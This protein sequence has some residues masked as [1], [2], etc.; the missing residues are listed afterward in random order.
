M[1]TSP[2]HLRMQTDITRENLSRDVDALADKVSPSA[3]VGRRKASMQNRLTRMRTAVMGSAEQ[4]TST[5][6]DASRSAMEGVAEAGGAVTA[7]VQEAP[8]QIKRTTQGSPIAA[9]LVAFG[10]G[11]I[12]SALLPTSKTEQQTAMR[13]KDSAEPA[14]APLKDHAR[15]A[16]TEMKDELQPAARDAV[17]QIKETASEAANETRQHAQQAAADVAGHAQQASSTTA[18]EAQDRVRHMHSA[19]GAENPN[20]P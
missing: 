2:D 17:T 16:A 19:P 18:D 1:G 10:A 14:L 12:V 20:R 11:L 9:G 5:T 7:A 3:I 6:K 4:A 8:A 13:L 15:E